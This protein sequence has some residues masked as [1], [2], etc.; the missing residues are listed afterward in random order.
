[1]E[2]NENIQRKKKQVLALKLKE[3][4]RLYSLALQLL[5]TLTSNPQHPTSNSNYEA[6]LKSD[7][8]F[9]YELF[10]D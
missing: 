5:P 8:E 3:G 10:D 1:M 4:G 9:D 6:I 2:E 7:Y